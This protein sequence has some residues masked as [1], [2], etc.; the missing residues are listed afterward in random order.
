MTSPIGVPAIGVS[1]VNLSPP[2]SVA[3]P[4]VFEPKTPVW[5]IAIGHWMEGPSYE[6]SNVRNWQ[7]ES[8][9]D[10]PDTISFSLDGDSEDAQRIVEL[11]T[12]VWAY[13]DG[14]AMCRNRVLN[15]NDNIGDSNEVS[16]DGSSYAELL[17][18]R[19]LRSQ[20]YNENFSFPGWKPI[21]IV[22]YLIKHAEAQHG[23]RLGINLA[24]DWSDLGI[25]PYE[26]HLYDE[27]GNDLGGLGEEDTA[28]V[29]EDG[30]AILDAINR[31]QSMEP[32]FD[33]W[34]DSDLA[35][36]VALQRGKDIGVILDYGGTVSAFSRTFSPD[37]YANV[38]EGTMQGGAPFWLP[39]G[40]RALGKP[41]NDTHIAV[42]GTATGGSTTTLVDSS[43]SWTTNYFKNTIVDITGGTG[44]DQTGIITGNTAT[45]LT[46]SPAWTTA[47]NATSTYLITGKLTNVHG[48]PEPPWLRSGGWAAV[49]PTEAESP[50]VLQSA[51]RASYNDLR[52]K[53]YTWNV[54]FAKGAWQGMDHVWTGDYVVFSANRGR[55]HINKRM[56]VLSMSISRDQ[57]GNETVTATLDVND[58]QVIALRRFRK[59]VK[60]LMK[61]KRK[62][63]K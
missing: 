49:R 3:R 50:A 29:I 14:V 47:P 13:R 31:M 53:Q 42:S 60:D 51:V 63:G 30:A 22:A 57:N 54:T 62:K 58:D 56:R 38:V 5:N 48:T 35:A 23:M 20:P 2:V 19:L 4:P 55:V 24:S 61:N 21:D 16:F 34:I 44:K 1:G 26:T 27:A 25:P 41:A 17:N 45:T 37:T 28:H 10:G 59:L 7:L 39:A 33:F 12:D 46:V 32:K 15:S 6:L 40:D 11:E 18:R 43:A 52:L 9:L 8:R 36:H